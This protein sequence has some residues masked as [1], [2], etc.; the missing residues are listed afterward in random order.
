MEYEFFSPLE[1]I[2]EQDKHG[3]NSGQYLGL[4]H[5][6]VWSTP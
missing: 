5:L 2:V 4:N 1:S 6:D 3:Q